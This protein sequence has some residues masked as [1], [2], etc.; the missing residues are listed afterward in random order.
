MIQSAEKSVPAQAGARSGGAAAPKKHPNRSTGFE[1][2]LSKLR[3]GSMP[4]TREMVS[5]AVETALASFGQEKPTLAALFASAAHTAQDAATV[6]GYNTEKN[7]PIAV[8]CIQR[9]MWD[10]PTFRGK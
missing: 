9:L 5:D 1:E 3:I 8:K 2:E 10:R 6:R 4:E 7:W